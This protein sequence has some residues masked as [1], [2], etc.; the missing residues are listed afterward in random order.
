MV[1]DK[2]PNLLLVAGTGTNAGKT[3]VICRIIEQYDYMN[4]TAVK[5]TPHFHV[6]TPGLVP[7]SEGKGY[8]IYEETNREGTKDTTRMLRAGASKVYFAKVRDDQLPDVFNRIMEKTDQDIPVICESSALRHYVEPGVFIIMTSDKVNKNL[9]IS[10]L[11]KLPHLMLK[12]EDMD[13]MPE[14]PVK[15]ENGSWVS[16]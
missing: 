11:Q 3:S 1:F 10:N 15:F 7:I 12:Y 8:A 14:I 6:T 5:I 13:T 16:E 2:I 4:I 9:D